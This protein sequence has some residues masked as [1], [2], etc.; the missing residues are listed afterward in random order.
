M[1]SVSDILEKIRE[2]ALH[3]LDLNGQ[4][5][6]FEDMGLL[7][8][9]L[10]KN[11]SVTEINLRN[12]PIS[13]DNMKELSEFFKNNRTITNVYIGGTIIDFGVF[14]LAHSLE[15]NPNLLYLDIGPK[16]MRAVCDR[17]KRAVLALFEKTGKGIG[18]LSPSDIKE[19]RERLPAFVKFGEKELKLTEES[20]AVLLV[21]IHN[22]AAE[23]GAKFQIPARYEDLYPVSGEEVREL[24]EKFDPEKWIK[25]TEEMKAEWKKTPPY[26]Q[27]H[28]N[29]MAALNKA[30]LETLKRNSPGKNSPKKP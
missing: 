21:E 4:I 20:I 3:R 14:S 24:R 28:F 12:C 27:K 19:I 29:F 22:R 25:N 30:R 8:E 17:N 7:I 10:K 16:D 13:Q 26:L 5:I 1:E 11:K 9:A 15:N 23:I 6:P 2:N 18:K